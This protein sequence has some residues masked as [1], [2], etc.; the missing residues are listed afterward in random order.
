MLILCVRFS[1]F[2][3]HP[4]QSTGHP[5]CL[6]SPVSAQ[7]SVGLSA[8]LQARLHC[9]SISHTRAPERGLLPSGDAGAGGPSGLFR[10]SVCSRL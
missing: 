3:P 8:P 4:S 9:S 2:D 7:P 6:L 1:Q 10:E 5:R